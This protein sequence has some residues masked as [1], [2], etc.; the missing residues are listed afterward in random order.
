MPLPDKQCPYQ[1][2]E[3]AVK[4]GSKSGTLVYIHG[5]FHN[6]QGRSWTE[7]PKSMH[8]VEYD[9]RAKEEGLPIDDNVIWAGPKNCPGKH[10]FLLHI[11]EVE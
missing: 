9:F 4:N 6:V 11:S 5:W 1:Y 7:C 3:I 10:Q 2:S 8:A